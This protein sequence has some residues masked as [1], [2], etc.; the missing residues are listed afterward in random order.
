MKI[1]FTAYCHPESQG[2]IKAFLLPNKEAVDLAASQIMGQRGASMS[3][4]VDIITVAVKK[5][6]SILTSDNPNLKA[7]RR[8][9]SRIAVAKMSGSAIAGKHVPVEVHLEFVFERPASVSARRVYPVVKPDI[10]KL[11]RATL[12]AL[13]G[14]VYEDDA[15]VVTVSKAKRYGPRECVSIRAWSLEDLAMPLSLFPELPPP[16]KAV[17]KPKP[18]LD[19]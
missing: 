10:D 7:F 6:R 14:T 15:Q 12:D 2:S 11:E 16:P 19:W 17:V 8:E 18:D 13:T 3:W 4:I 1:E 5:A 9:V